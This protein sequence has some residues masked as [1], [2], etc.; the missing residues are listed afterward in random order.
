MADASKK[1]SNFIGIRE[2]NFEDYIRDLDKD[3]KNL[4]LDKTLNLEE[5]KRYA[6]IATVANDGA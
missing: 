1:K 2:E 4:F 3:V 5:S 6:Y